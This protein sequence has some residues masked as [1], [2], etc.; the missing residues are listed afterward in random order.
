M[1][2]VTEIKEVNSTCSGG[3]RNCKK[4]TEEK[5]IKSFPVE[6]LDKS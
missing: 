5:K 6:T 2:C 4:R 3:C 1:S